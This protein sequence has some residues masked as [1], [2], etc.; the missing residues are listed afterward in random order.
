MH[1]VVNPLAGEE[2]LKEVIQQLQLMGEVVYLKCELGE[3]LI[4]LDPAWLCSSLAGSVLSPDFRS[5]CP[6]SG[7]Y[8]LA[9]FQLAAPEHE[10]G[11]AV[12]VLQALGL[13]T[14]L[15]PSEAGGAPS[16]ELPALAEPS[17]EAWPA[18]L[19]HSGRWG[20][21]LLQPAA[22]AAGPLLGPMFP[23]IQVNACHSA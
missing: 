22:A 5:R 16:W 9:E 14:R 13:A 21:V 20:G 8:T 15:Q 18:G 6:A 11:P 2:H 3:D 17:E 19:L 1:T 10:A 4:V 12:A 23:R 7:R